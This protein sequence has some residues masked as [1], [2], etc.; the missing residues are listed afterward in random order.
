[1]KDFIVVYHVK[2]KTYR[3][4][5][6]NSEQGTAIYRNLETNIPFIWMKVKWMRLL[7]IL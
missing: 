4:I 3:Y 5:I 6:N 2:R 1:M 7:N